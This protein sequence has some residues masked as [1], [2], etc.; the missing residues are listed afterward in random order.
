M[1]RLRQQLAYFFGFERR[2]INGFIL[3]SIV[4]FGTLLVPIIIKTANKPT[5]A[6]LVQGFDTLNAEPPKFE[7]ALVAKKVPKQFELHRFNPNIASKKEMLAMGIPYKVARTIENYVKKGGHFKRKNDLLKIYGMQDSLYAALLPYVAI[8]L[9]ANNSKEAHLQKSLPFTSERAVVLPPLDLNS[10]D[11]TALQRLKGIG[12]VLSKRVVKFREK[13][14]GFYAVHQL[15]EVY[16]VSDSTYQSLV[17]T[18]VVNKPKLSLIK[19]NLVGA[20]TLAMHP[21][22]SK[23]KARL[24]VAFRQQHGP[25]LSKQE[26]Y[27]IKAIDSVFYNKVSPY[28]SVH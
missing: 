21:Y 20:D 6:T 3:L 22:I 28:L 24:I 25:Y 13:L 17:E 9:V 26:L 15:G 8:P 12:P 14:G 27:K 19:L 11:A 10:A 5:R 18:V 7:K 4:V 23:N 16:G 2:E 1:R